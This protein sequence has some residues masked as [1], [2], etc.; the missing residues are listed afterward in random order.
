MEL[1]YISAYNKRIPKLIFSRDTSSN[2]EKNSPFPHH[3]IMKYISNSKCDRSLNITQEQIVSN[4]PLY[5][6]TSLIQEKYKG[7][8]QGMAAVLCVNKFYDGHFTK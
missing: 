5:E 7:Q 6:D 3:C 4:H 8:R 2:R 1:A